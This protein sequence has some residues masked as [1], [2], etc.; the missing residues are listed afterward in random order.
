[1]STLGPNIYMYMWGKYTKNSWR[2]TII[3]NTI[4]H[5]VKSCRHGTETHTKPDDH[6]NL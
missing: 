6:H 2:N 5:Q 3:E 4:I 1:M